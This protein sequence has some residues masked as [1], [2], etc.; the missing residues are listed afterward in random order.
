MGLSHGD[1]RGEGKD[2]WRGLRESGGEGEK[3]GGREGGQSKADLMRMRIFFFFFK[4]C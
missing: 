4:E 2:F 1:R 3:G